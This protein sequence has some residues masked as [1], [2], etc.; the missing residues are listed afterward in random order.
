MLELFEALNSVSGENYSIIIA[1]A[2]FL[3]PIG[4]SIYHRIEIHGWGIKAKFE[5]DLFYPIVLFLSFI[6]I[7]AIAF[8]HDV[9]Y[10]FVQKI[11]TGNSLKYIELFLLFLLAFLCLRGFLGL[12]FIRLR[13]IGMSKWYYIL[14]CI[15]FISMT[16]LLILFALKIDTT[17]YIK[18][19]LICFLV[20]ET[21]GMMLFPARYKRY[22]YSYVD[23]SLKNGEKIKTVN[24]DNISRKPGW[25]V[26]K[27]VKSETRIK[28]DE[29]FKVKYYGEPKSVDIDNYWTP[30]LKRLWE[31][32]QKIK[33][34]F[35]IK[36]RVLKLCGR[37]FLALG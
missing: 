33:L 11:F 25:I 12:K 22:K 23:I 15:P 9:T 7:I 27:K 36:K 26:V 6:G 31:N 37:Y 4:N 29:L 3:W 5:S 20:A 14:V 32:I 8:V 16:L 28:S 17:Y 35:F 10:V 18:I 21:L 2:L 24:I 19:S 30:L 1:V 34:I 13:L